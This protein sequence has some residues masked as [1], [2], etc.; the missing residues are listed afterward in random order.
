MQKHEVNNQYLSHIVDDP[1]Q[2]L[3]FLLTFHAYFTIHIILWDTVVEDSNDSE[4]NTRKNHYPNRQFKKIPDIICTE[5]GLKIL[6]YGDRLT[7]SVGENYGSY[8]ISPLLKAAFIM[9]DCVEKG[10]G[11]KVKISGIP[12][13]RRF[14]WRECTQRNIAVSNFSPSTADHV[15]HKLV[16]QTQRR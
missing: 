3:G 14:A 1:S 4:R 7:S 9:V 6:D 2:Y 10:R 8:C 16:L 5:S 11:T 12:Q 13:A 15:R